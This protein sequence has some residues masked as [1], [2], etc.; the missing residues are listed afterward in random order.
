MPIENQKTKFNK[1]SRKRGKYYIDKEKFTND[2]LE[3]KRKGR[4]TN[5]AFEQMQLL[6]DRLFNSGKLKYLD[7]NDRED[8]RSRVWIDLLSGWHK[9]SEERKD[10]F[11]YFTSFVFTGAAKEWNALHAKNN[12]YNVIHMS[13]GGEDNEIYTI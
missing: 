9:F 5:E 11:S 13:G 3:S 7:P 2:I 6:V 1:M 10:A 12:K 8:C 4:L